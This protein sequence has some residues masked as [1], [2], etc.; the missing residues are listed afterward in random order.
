MHEVGDRKT[1]TLAA[2]SS[3]ADMRGEVSCAACKAL[4]E[5]G[6]DAV[7]AVVVVCVYAMRFGALYRRGQRA[8]GRVKKGEGVGLSGRAERLAGHVAALVSRLLLL[9]GQ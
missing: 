8:G 2:P 7:V 3:L 4:C 9:G 5:T 6:T 1:K